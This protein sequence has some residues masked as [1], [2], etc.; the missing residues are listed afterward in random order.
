MAWRQRFAIAC[1]DKPL[2]TTSGAGGETVNEKV[3]ISW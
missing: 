1:E 3:K 2:G